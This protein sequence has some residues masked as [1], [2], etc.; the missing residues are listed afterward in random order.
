M[1]DLKEKLSK[2]SVLVFGDMYLDRDCI[3]DFEGKSKED[4]HM[5]ILKAHTEKY[6]PGGAGNLASCFAA[7]GV[8]TTVIGLWGEKEDINRQILE[9]QFKSRGVDTSYMVESG[10][11]FVFG[12]FYTSDSEHVFRYD[13]ISDSMTDEKQ[14]II[15]SNLEKVILNVNFVACADYNNSGIRDLVCDRT[16]NPFF[17]EN[18]IKFATGRKEINKFKEFNCIILNN[19]EFKKQSI[20]DNEINFFKTLNIGSLVVT[21]ENGAI[22]FDV[23]SNKFES[24]SKKIEG[25]IDTCG[26][27][28]MF[29]AMYASSIMAHYGMQE[30]LDLANL[31]A[32]IVAKK[33]FG[34][35]QA[36]IDEIISSL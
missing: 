19:E 17:K 13:I 33:K 18:I 35:A 28:D 7:L 15:I 6:Q 31:A 22:G 9:Q 1:N 20:F 16:L 32:G 8:K 14:N 26:C 30:S 27:G 4:E 11:T 3:G 24:K 2:L 12:K 10:K 36:S 25:D 23:N 5:P 34:A 21:S 29:Y